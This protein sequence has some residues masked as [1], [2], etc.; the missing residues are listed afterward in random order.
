MTGPELYTHKVSIPLPPDDELRQVLGESYNAAETLNVVKMF[1]GTHDMCA[2][3]MGLVRAVFSAEGIDPKVRQAI[4]LRAAVVLNAPYEWQANV[5]MSRNNGLSE[6]EIECIGSLDANSQLPVPY[7]LV[8]TATDEMCATGTLTDE[9]LQQLL[10]AY[11]QTITRKLVLMIAWFNLLSL[12]LNGCRVPLE[13]TDKI[14]SRTS[15]LG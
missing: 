11:G 7:V 6:T 9:T 5:A 1:A 15:P 10:D 8:C 12:F 3:T 2:A 14:G 4:I 13:L